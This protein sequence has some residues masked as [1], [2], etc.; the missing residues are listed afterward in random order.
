MISL[1]YVAHRPATARLELTISDRRERPHEETKLLPM[2][3]FHFSETEKEA[4]VRVLH[5][6][7]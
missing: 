7:R 4:N 2:T 1:Q 6:R 5:G 3:F